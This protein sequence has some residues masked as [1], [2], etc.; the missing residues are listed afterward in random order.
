VTFESRNVLVPYS[1]RTVAGI[2]RVG[3]ELAKINIELLLIN[4][5]EDLRVKNFCVNPNLPLSK[6]KF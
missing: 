4:T 1:V 5:A 6:R 2:G 3:T